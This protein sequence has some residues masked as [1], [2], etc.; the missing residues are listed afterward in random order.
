MAYFIIINV[1]GIVLI[2]IYFPLIF[3]WTLSISALPFLV[4]VT[5]I[6]TLSFCNQ[7]CNDLDTI[8]YILLPYVNRSLDNLYKISI[9]F[10]CTVHRF[11][12]CI[13]ILFILEYFLNIIVFRYFCNFWQRVLSCTFYF[14]TVVFHIVYWNIEYFIF[15]CYVANKVYGRSNHNLRLLPKR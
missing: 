4:V 1:Y 9:I 12:F 2:I 3:L 10:L 8:F 5:L 15:I 11:C 14:L 6:L 13:Y 7:F